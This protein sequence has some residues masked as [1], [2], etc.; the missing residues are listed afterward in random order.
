MNPYNQEDIPL[1]GFKGLFD[2][3]R[4]EVVPTDHFIDCLNLRFEVA[5]VK[6]REGMVESVTPDPAVIKLI[7][8]YK[9]VRHFFRYAEGIGNY[10]IFLLDDGRLYG[11]A[12]GKTTLLLNIAAMKDFSLCDTFSRVYITPH[13]G[14]K[15]LA[16]EKVYWWDKTT[17][18][19][20][21]GAAPVAAVP[22]SFANNGS[23]QDEVQTLTMTGT[24]TSGSLSFDTPYGK[25]VELPYNFTTAQIKSCLEGDNQRQAIWIKGAAGGT[26]T[27]E[28]GGQISGNIAWN[29]NAATVK[30]ALEGIPNIGAGNIDVLSG[31]GTELSPWLILFIGTLAKQPQGLLIVNGSNLTGT[32]VEIHVD[33]VLPGRTLYGAGNIDV[34]DTAGGTPWVITFKNG[35]GKLDQP[36]LIVNNSL[37]GVNPAFTIVETTRG[38][39]IGSIDQGTHKFAVAYET[40]TGFIT[41]PGVKIAGVFT[42]S[43][44]DAPGA[45]KVEIS[46]IPLG[47]AGT[48]ARHILATKS[49]EEEFFYVPNGRLGNNTDDTFVVDFYDSDLLESADYLFDLLEEIP[50]CLKIIKYG[51]RFVFVGYGVPNNS[52]A[53]ISRAGE[54]E[55]LDQVEGIYLVNPDDRFQLKTAFEYR[56]IIYWVKTLGVFASQDN[57]QEAAYWETAVVIDL[58]VGGEVNSVAELPNVT[59]GVTK[60]RVLFLDR[61]GLLL[62]DGAFRRPELTWKI[63][64]RWLEIN[65]DKF[66]TMQLWDD[67]VNQF[68][69]FNCP[70][71]IG[72]EV[73]NYVFHA[74]YSECGA[75]PDHE[76]IKW[77]PWHFNHDDPLSI[78]VFD[79]GGKGRNVFRFSGIKIW[80]ACRAADSKDDYNYVIDCFIRFAY[81]IPRSASGDGLN[82]YAFIRMRLNGVGN[83][84]ITLYGID[85]NPVSFPPFVLASQLPS[86]EFDRLVNFINER[87]SIR[88][89]VNALDEWFNVFRVVAFGK[90]YGAS[91][92]R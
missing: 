14:L 74:D 64:D 35:A 22:M 23:G 7:G 65:K 69:Y 5:G 77:T 27:V 8:P 86:Q 82:H 6:T 12:D 53:R 78:S 9:V 24:A 89:G 21:G 41:P 28:F 4:D 72:Q 38:V 19:A 81:V 25:T 36:L 50:S 43:V 13:D 51:A 75:Y 45:Y 70:Y 26:F 66:H 48:V 84:D 31:A 55:S 54:F 32:S 1:E 87:L 2:R 46:A 37:T 63:N 17:F 83:V 52:L 62:F 3:G 39:P 16:N 88:I 73:P 80:R 40:E 33:E 92:P 67:P 34:T 68:I 44:Y 29:A 90:P 15:G 60:E 58:G 61:S 10:L 47:P 71:G 91:R 20:A 79:L 18:R 85:D 56:N 76:N 11:Q 30:A 59:E 42:P 49:G 57:G